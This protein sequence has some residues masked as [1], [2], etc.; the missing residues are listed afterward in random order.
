MKTRDLNK[1]VMIVAAALT[2]FALKISAFAQ[3]DAK[4]EWEQVLAAGKKEGKV[5]INIPPSPELRKALEAAFP[6]KF[7]IDIEIAVGQG[8]QIARK[9]AEEYKAGV[10]YF[11]IVTGSFD[12]TA[13][14]LLALGAVD[15]MEPNWILP[16]VKDPKRWWSG[17][18]WGDKAGRLVYYPTAFMVDN[19]WYNAE[20][21]KPEELRSYDDLL[22]PK[23]TGKIGIF[24]PFSGGAGLAICSYLWMIK[25]EG[26]LKQLAKQQLLVADRRVVGESLAKGKIAISLGATYYTFLPFI[27]AGLPV[28]PFPRFK[29]GT[30]ATAGN[31]GPVIIK[32][33]PHPNATKVFINWF[34]SKEGQDLYDKAFGNATRRLDVDTKWLSQYGVHAAKDSMTLGEYMKVELSSEDKIK[35]V[36]NPVQELMRQLLS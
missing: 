14:S 5:V 34:L 22:N 18:L 32:N 11:D 13:D 2:F 25:G 15:A 16:E 30:Y 35:K 10:K 24:D 27:K 28:K 9:A 1:T 29:E 4:S 21:V 8:A 3:M 12:S 6:S 36:R 33:R 19:L 20:L 7:G 17:H 23:W 26:F 31:G